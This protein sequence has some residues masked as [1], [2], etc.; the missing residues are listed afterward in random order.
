MPAK[1]P[2]RNE[3]AMWSRIF[4]YQTQRSQWAKFIKSNKLLLNMELSDIIT[5][6]SMPV[7]FLTGLNMKA[8][9]DTKKMVS[10]A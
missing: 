3:N 5:V 4:A 7:G 10:Y 6:V 2:K 9:E 8:Y 1:C